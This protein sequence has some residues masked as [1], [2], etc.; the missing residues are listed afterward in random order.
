M[1]PALHRQL[2]NHIHD[3]LLMII[4]VMTKASKSKHHIIREY[5][6]VA[7]KLHGFLTFAPLVLSG[8]HHNYTTLISRQEILEGVEDRRH[9][10]VNRNSPCLSVIQ[11]LR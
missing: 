1:L 9:M 7:V 2:R 4:K 10:N 3:V 5:G 8:A 6:G 11:K